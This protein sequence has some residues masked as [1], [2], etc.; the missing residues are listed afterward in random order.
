MEANV[1]NHWSDE[2]HVSTAMGRTSGYGAL[3]LVWTHGCDTQ[4]SSNDLMGYP[5]W[6]V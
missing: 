4:I 6:R 3:L 2:L 5:I 1:K